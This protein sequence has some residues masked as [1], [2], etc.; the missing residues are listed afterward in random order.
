MKNIFRKFVSKLFKKSSYTDNEYFYE[1]KKENSISF[2]LDKDNNCIIQINVQ[3]FDDDKYIDKFAELIFMM[4]H[5]YYQKNIVDIMADMAVSDPNRA[6]FLSNVIQK[7]SSYEDKYVDLNQKTKDYNVDK[8]CV[9]PLS[10]S[11]IVSQQ[12]IPT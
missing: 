12:N 1:R 5:G 9:S 2:I 6:L 8:P 11:K 3:H 10:F 7:W 4:N